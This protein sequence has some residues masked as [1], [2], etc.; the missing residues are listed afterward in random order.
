MICWLKKGCNGTFINVVH[1][2]VFVHVILFSPIDESQ[3]L[4]IFR[5][6]SQRISLTFNFLDN[7]TQFDDFESVAFRYFWNNEAFQETFSRYVRN[8]KEF[9]IIIIIDNN[10]YRPTSKHRMCK[11]EETDYSLIFFL[12]VCIY[13]YRDLTER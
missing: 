12:F 9:C 6:A 2:Q 4:F 3:Y 7:I 8:I 1:P 5:N 11:V 10:P 13:Q